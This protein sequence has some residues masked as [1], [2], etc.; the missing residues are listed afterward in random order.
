MKVKTNGIEINCVTEGEGPWVVLSHSLGCNLHMW[1]EQARVLSAH[2][3]VLRFDTRGHGKSDA[4]FGPY[5]LEQLADDVHGLLE[6]FAI[7]RVHF[8][9]LSMGGMIAQGFALKYP[10]K[11]QSLTL[12]GTTSRCPPAALPVWEERIRTVTEQGMEPMVQPTLARWFTAPFL[13]NRRDVTDAV[14]AMIRATP[15]QGYA[16]CCHAISRIDYASRLAE[17][18]CPSLVIVGEDDPGAPVAT[19]RE[20]HG[21][22]PGSQLV[23]LPSCSH[24]SN[25]EQPEAFNRA[26][27]GFLDGAE[28]RG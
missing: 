13:E 15:P 16:G 5:T 14:A 19:A 23:I 26:L 18:H 21:A 10:Q 27:T 4:P 1:D 3:R 17:I 8:V 6:A 24:L 9:G 2:H 12:C 28:G 11:A 7:E 20:I 22:I 25:L